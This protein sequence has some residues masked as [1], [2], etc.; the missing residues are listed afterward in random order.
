MI[1]WL[2]KRIGTSAFETVNPSPGCVIVDVRNLV[3]KHGNSPEAIWQKIQESRKALDS[4]N[5]VVICCDYGTSRSN[6]IA[7][8]LFSVTEKVPFAAAMEYFIKTIGEKEIKIE[9]LNDVRRAVEIFRSDN[10]YDSSEPSEVTI[11]MTGAGGYIAKPL[12]KA[13]RT[14]ISLITPSSSEINLLEGP[15]ELDC[16][17]KKKNITHIL[18]LANF[19]NLGRNS[20]LG[21]ALVMMKN[22]LDVSR[23]N[24]IKL[25][26]FS[27]IDIYSGYCS[28]RLLASESLQAN[29]KGTPGETKMLCEKLLRHYHDLYDLKYLIIRPSLVYGGEGIQPKFIFNFLSKAIRGENIAVHHYRN[30]CPVLDLIHVNDLIEAVTAAIKSLH[31]GTF[32]VGSAKGYTTKEIAETICDIVGSNSKVE[33]KEIDDVSSNVIMDISKISSMLDWTP[34][35]SLRTGLE[36]WIERH[37][38]DLVKEVS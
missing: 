23:E 21:E 3:D 9:T 4:G 10:K 32:N 8:G 2:T 17:A 7:I 18:H 34:Q 38:G 30:G 28:N 25:V 5:Q 27:S 22:L 16:L 33:C 20:A 37:K 15:I 29:P 12:G 35:I 11:L 31:N 14:H 19:S 6:A 13:L 26:F 36:N 24:A 1:R